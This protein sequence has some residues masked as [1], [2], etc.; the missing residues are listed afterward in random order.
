MSAIVGA[1]TNTNSGAG[2]QAQSAPV[3]NPATTQQAQDQYNTST[4][5][6]SQQQ[7]FLQ[8][9]LGQNGLG[10]QSQVFNAL[11]GVAN[12]TGPN[13]AQAQLAQ[14]TGANVANTASLLAGQ[15]G[16]SANVG[17]AARQAAQQGAATQQNAAGQAATL[18]ANQSLNAL[19][20]QAG[21]A[22][23][24]ATNALQGVQ[25]YSNAAQN[26][27]SNILNA[28][29]NQNQA[30]IS[31]TAQQ[32][33]ANAG[34]AQG[35][36]AM[37]GQILG[38]LLGGAAAA[39]TKAALAA[40]GG[41]IRKMYAEG[42]A[43]VTSSP[44]PVKTPSS[45]LGRFAQGMANSSDKSGLYNGMNKVGAGI[46]N[47]LISAFS[48]SPTPVPKSTVSGGALDNSGQQPS[49]NTIAPNPSPDTRMAARGGQIRMELGGNVPALLSPG[50]KV[51]DPETAKKA[52]MGQANPI[53]DGKTVPGK[54]V[55]GGAKN[56]YANDIVKA[57]PKE[58]SIVIPRSVTQSKD[59]EEKAIQF[60]R[61]VFAKK[62]AL[63]KRK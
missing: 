24:Q 5:A 44:N 57:N 27:Q 36:Q 37:Q 25:G 1:L 53:R 43:D 46:T 13:P 9:L 34:I 40:G 6:L 42:S 45:A 2:F 29:T 23:T 59:S 62:G 55:V 33:Q 4:N 10:N 20:Q 19:N 18:Q 30:N 8:S 32:N 12:G 17:L 7:A 11:T 41:E 15:R 49:I 31:N 16:S 51:L 63:P 50:E 35:N 48:S 52:A 22:N 3:I 28:I 58:G 61:D 60:V 54:P 39:G 56:S 47:G 26:E 21:I 14:A 38:G